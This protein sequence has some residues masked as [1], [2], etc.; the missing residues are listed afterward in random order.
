MLQDREDAEGR[1]FSEGGKQDKRILTAGE[2]PLLFS[3]EGRRETR[4]QNETGGD[5]MT[6]SPPAN[7]CFL[8]EVC[9]EG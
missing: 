5:K 9:G 6:A 8:S 2:I 7:L 1:K 4:T 3:Q